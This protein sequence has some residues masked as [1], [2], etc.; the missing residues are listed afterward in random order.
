[1]GE[2]NKET[3]LS[4]GDF[5]I[6]TQ[7]NVLSV[8]MDSDALKPKVKSILCNAINSLCDLD[9]APETFSKRQEE[10]AG[11]VTQMY[12]ALTGEQVEDMLKQALQRV[13]SGQVNA[14]EILR[15]YKTGLSVEAARLDAL[16][17]PGSII[18]SVEYAIIAPDQ[19]KPGEAV[20]LE[21]YEKASSGAQKIEEAL[22]AVRAF[23]FEHPSEAMAK[24]LRE[25]FNLSAE[26]TASVPTF[27]GLAA[28]KEK[29]M[30]A[31]GLQELLKADKIMVKSAASVLEDVEKTAQSRLKMLDEGKV[32]RK[33]S[34]SEQTL[35][36]N[37][38]DLLSHCDEAIYAE[39][40]V[41]KGLSEIQKALKGTGQ[42]NTR[43]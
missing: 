30:A 36:S 5:S 27:A 29:G 26:Y 8:M 6:G 24:D 41:L 21:A 39:A 28:L 16:R 35:A 32:G 17:D 33:L 1:M 34:E 20:I 31:E 40:D 12:G 2:D 23:M 11:V 4:A 19:E 14:D 7:L 22:Q 18:E 10:L 13:P 37:L 25:K 38:D 42:S 3:T 15:L 43:G 9:L